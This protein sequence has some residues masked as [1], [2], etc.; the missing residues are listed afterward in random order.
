M[1]LI[2]ISVTVGV[3]YTDIDDRTDILHFRN[4]EIQALQLEMSE[5][6]KC[7]TGWPGDIT[8]EKCNEKNLVCS[9]SDKEE[10][11][12]NQNDIQ[13]G[14][15]DKIE[16]SND[17]GCGSADLELYPELVAYRYNCPKTR[18]F[19]QQLLDN[20]FFDVSVT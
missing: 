15:T 18:I 2:G 16:I 19:F 3:T 20:S 7:L 9:D 10:V 17:E 4:L 11:E 6:K 5:E 1:F 12:V 13:H 14:K 8:V